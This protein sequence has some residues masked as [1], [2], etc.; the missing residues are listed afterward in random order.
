[1]PEP[2]P[3]DPFAPAL[4]RIVFEVRG[5]NYTLGQVL[6]AAAVGGWIGRFWSDLEDALACTAYAGDEGFEVDAQALQES[7]DRF[8][9]ARNLVTAEETERWLSDRDVDEDDLVGWLERRYWLERFA[10]K[11]AEIR[12]AYAPPPSVA[13]DVLWPEVTFSG[14]LGSLAVPLARRVVAGLHGGPVLPAEAPGE[15]VAEARA[16]I[17]ARSTSGP[18]GLAAW[19]ARNH[20]PEAWF[21]E[22]IVLEAGYRRACA[23]ACSDDRC[24]AALDPRRLELVRVGHRYARFPT[25]RQ[26]REAY[27][28]IV[29]DGDA[30]DDAARRAAVPVEERELLLE[31]APAALQTLLLSAAPGETFLAT[32]SEDE[33]VVVQVV[34][35]TLPRIADPRVRSRLEPLLVSRFFDPLV[36]AHVRWASPLEPSP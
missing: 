25:E 14:C 6:S 22:M 8:R 30:F 20:C 1:M 35:K 21:N 27:R 9:Y 15:G 24:A 19:L 12:P 16:E 33:P 2:E 10:A 3:V 29:D 17:L 26:A 18:E 31:D 34:D 32:V 13:S 7:A 5:K 36:E 28:C 23:A 4:S 11:A